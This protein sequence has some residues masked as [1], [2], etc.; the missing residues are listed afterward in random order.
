[1]KARPEEHR[2]R[3]VVHRKTRSEGIPSGV[4]GEVYRRMKVMNRQSALRST[5]MSCFESG[6]K[7]RGLQVDGDD[8]CENDG[9]FPFRGSVHLRSD[10]CSFTWLAFT[11]L[12]MTRVCRGAILDEFEVGREVDEEED[13]AIQVAV[14]TEGAGERMTYMTVKTNH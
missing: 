8:P 3:K 4:A 14:R 1:M 11:V 13:E 6:G 5:K 7:M 12:W 2:P 9:E 10:P